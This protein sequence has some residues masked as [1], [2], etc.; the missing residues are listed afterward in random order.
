MSPCL[1]AA[2]REAPAI[3]KV[4]RRDACVPAV[5]RNMVSAV[6][7]GRNDKAARTTNSG[8]LNRIHLKTRAL[9]WAGPIATLAPQRERRLRQAADGGAKASLLQQAPAE[10]AAQWT[11][12]PAPRPSADII[13]NSGALASHRAEVAP[14]E[15]RVEPRPLD[16]PPQAAVAPPASPRVEDSGAQQKAADDRLVAEITARMRALENAADKKAERQMAVGESLSQRS[17]IDDVAADILAEKIERDRAG[18]GTFSL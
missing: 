16:R 1:P 14:S 11:P 7:P 5:E 13:P 12:A 8:H 18:E 3:Q 2:A 10:T 9:A 4:F 17:L 15:P 6:I